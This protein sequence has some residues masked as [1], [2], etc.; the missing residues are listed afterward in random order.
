MYTLLSLKKVRFSHKVRKET[1]SEGGDKVD[2]VGTT[3]GV[4]PNISRSKVLIFFLEI[5]LFGEHEGNKMDV[6]LNTN[7]RTQ[8][9]QKR[10]VRDH[11]SRNKILLLYIIFLVYK[12]RY[13]SVFIN[14]LGPV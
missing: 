9:V 5:H 8:S 13:S 2:P 11:R 6:S 1:K 3:F 4:G 7:E 10:E 14:T 12:T